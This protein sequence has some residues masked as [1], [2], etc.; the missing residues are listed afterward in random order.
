MPA[1]GRRVS[2]HGIIHSRVRDGRIG[3]EWE[4]MDEATL[5]RQMEGAPH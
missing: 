1:T 3:E 5:L 2:V 4:L